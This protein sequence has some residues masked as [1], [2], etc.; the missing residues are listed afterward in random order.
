MTS[1]DCAPSKR[2]LVDRL[3]EQRIERRRDEEVEVGD[4]RQLAERQRRREIRVAQDAAHARVGLFAP[5]VRRQEPADDVVERVGL[6]QPRGIDVELAGELFRDPVVEQ[7][8]AGLGLD[9]QQ[10]RPDDRDDAALLDEVEQVLP[11][12]V[13]ERGERGVHGKQIAHNPGS[14]AKQNR[15]RRSVHDSETRVKRSSSPRLGRHTASRRCQAR[16]RAKP[17]ARSSIRSSGSSR[18][19]CSLR[20]GPSGAQRVTLRTASGRPGSPGSRSRPS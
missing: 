10:L 13:I 6:R 11:R 15:A 7:A 20:Y 16:S 18:P 3:L 12:I 4:L 5:A 1:V 14:F 19:T 9:L 17:P 8:R 2:S